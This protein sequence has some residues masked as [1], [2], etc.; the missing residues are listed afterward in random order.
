[1]KMG[2]IRSLCPYEA[3]ACH[4]LQS[5]NLRRRTILYYA[6]RG[7][8]PDLARWS[9]YPSIAALSINLGIDVTCTSGRE[10]SQHGSAIIR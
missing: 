1:M 6:S 2:T 7:C 4:A 9:G 3:A 8:L 5:A 10:Q